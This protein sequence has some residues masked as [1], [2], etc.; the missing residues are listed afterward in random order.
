[1]GMRS[2]IIRGTVRERGAGRRCAIRVLIAISAGACQA[3]G[4]VAAAVTRMT[5]ML[6]SVRLAGWNSLLLQGGLLELMADAH[7]MMMPNLI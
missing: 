6:A 3:P 4:F 1:M 7:R 5:L 2:R